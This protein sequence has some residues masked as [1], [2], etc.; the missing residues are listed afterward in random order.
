[1]WCKR[2][3]MFFLQRYRLKDLKFITNKMRQLLSQRH[4]FYQASACL[5]FFALL[6]FILQYAADIFIPITFS[7]LLAFIVLPLSLKLEKWHFPRWASGM[8]G[9]LLVMVI[10]VGIITLLGYQLS[11][12][13]D[14]LPTFK[15]K[16]SERVLDFQK[17][18]RSAWGLTV[19]EQNTWI[20][21]Q[22]KK[23]GDGF[24]RYLMSFFSTT[25]TL[26]MNVFLVPILAFF[27][28]TYR[29]RF[30]NFLKLVDDKYHYHT[31]FIIAQIG[32]VSQE[33]LKGVCLDALIL[34]VLNFI[35]FWI[36][37][38]QYALLFAVLAA[39]LNIVPYIGGIVGSLF[40][41]F[42]ALVTM[43]NS[44]SAFGILG[45]CLF[46][47]FLDNNFIGPKVIGSSVSINPLFSTLAL[48]VG[49]LI[50]GT[51]GMLLAMPLAG[52]LKVVFDNIPELQ[53]YGYLMGEEDDFKRPLS[54]NMNLIPYL[55]HKLSSRS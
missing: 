9:V 36:F 50:W 18:I 52:M 46:V 44:W 2:C 47:Q 20:D 35:G 55:K 54:I 32:K 34:A 16:F 13:I 38:L 21:N 29:E 33:Y 23:S 10:M 17:Y 43:D 28:L 49:A 24:S 27:L 53:P 1:M 3:G 8:V 11:G 45:V 15:A 14:D 4:F 19:K 30:K 39:V 7:F 51:S 26:L 40:P 12:L 48:L 42:M 41:I 31:F 22:V 37:G 25:T 5:F 6:G